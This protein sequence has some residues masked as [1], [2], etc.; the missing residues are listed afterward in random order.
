MREDPEELIRPWV[1]VACFCTVAMQEVPPGGM[2]SLIRIF[3]RW[4]FNG[5]AAEMPPSTLQ[6]TMVI[7]LKSGQMRG[8]ATVKVRPL[9]PSKKELPSLEIPVL[10]E[11]D[12]RGVDIILPLVM[13]VQETGLY[14]FDVFVDDQIFTRIPL[15]VVYQKM[16]GIS[17]L[18]E[19]Q[20]PSD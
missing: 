16:P 14:W 15:R 12:D 17:P 9:T 19:S 7:M 1:Q 4:F 2:K 5:T 11:G 13:A 3:D 18:P 6:T 8:P 10:F 20:T